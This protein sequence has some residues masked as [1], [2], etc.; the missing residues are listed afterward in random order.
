MMDE[1]LDKLLSD[2]D[3]DLDHSASRERPVHKTQPQKPEK[4][5]GGTEPKEAVDSLSTDRQFLENMQNL[6]VD[7]AILIFDKGVIKALDEHNSF[8]QKFKDVLSESVTSEKLSQVISKYKYSFNRILENNEKYNDEYYAIFAFDSLF[9][10]AKKDFSLLFTGFETENK[11]DFLVL[12]EIFVKLREYNSKVRKEWSEM[13]K[14]I[15]AI[16]LV[17]EGKSLYMAMSSV[18]ETAVS[19][20]DTTGKFIHRIGKI[21]S[22]PE[23]SFDVA[24]RDIYG[25]LTYRESFPYKYAAIFDLK[26][27]LKTQREIKSADEILDIAEDKSD[28]KQ[29]AEENEIEK[30]VDEKFPDEMEI[31]KPVPV[32]TI[33]AEPPA[34]EHPAVNFT[35]RGK[36][37]WNTREP[38]IMSVDGARLQK[39]YDDLSM[40]FYFISA[41]ENETQ[42]EAS[43]KRAMVRY[44]SD[45]LKNITVEYEEYLFKTIIL[46]T[47]AM[48][49]FFNIQEDI[50]NL[51]IYHL[52]PLFIY[53]VISSIF[54]NDKIGLCFKYLSGNKVVRY[55]PQEFIKEKVLKWYEDNI[56]MLN[57]EF[58]KVN[59]FDE[60]RRSV[61]RKYNAE[62]DKYTVE[63]NKIILKDRLEENKQF[64]KAEFF[65]SKWNEWFG[66]ANIQVYNRFVERTIFK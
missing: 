54:N 7:E 51:F 43:V 55:L 2:V 18:V 49:K 40:S 10:K 29:E 50:S 11:V 16:N 60:I 32:E 31:K 12:K 44:L 61:F 66:T 17:S 48:I 14:A 37:A 8:S 36:S 13:S 57:L 38:Y 9:K 56:N 62:V 25:K 34:P 65:K 4:Y 1:D 39:D 53:R 33:P 59:V 21:L 23:D 27:Y 26:E 35:I 58:D 30:R 28:L 6:K 41:N 46:Q 47:R 20:C 42:L 45:T 64:N 19:F 5:E 3:G 52:G 63:L 22:I 24:E 15:G